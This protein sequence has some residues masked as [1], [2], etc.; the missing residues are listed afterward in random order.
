MSSDL[1][2]LS[3]LGT[4]RYLTNSRDMIDKSVKQV[5]K[6]FHQANSHT[7]LTSSSFKWPGAVFRVPDLFRWSLIASGSKH[8]EELYKAPE[9]VFSSM[10]AIHEVIS[11]SVRVLFVCK[12]SAHRQHSYFKLIIRS[13]LISEKTHIIYQ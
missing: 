2:F 5:T 9:N 10:E 4:F 11:I 3:Y 8:L 1:P 12:D 13:A 6:Y 7:N